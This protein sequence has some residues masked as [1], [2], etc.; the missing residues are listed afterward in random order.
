MEEHCSLKRSSPRSRFSFPTRGVRNVCALPGPLPALSLRAAFSAHEA[1]SRV[2]SPAPSSL[3]YGV[4][5]MGLLLATTLFRSLDSSP[6][7]LRS[8][9]ARLSMGAPFGVPQR[10][11]VSQAVLAGTG[12]LRNFHLAGNPLV[13][14]NP[15]PLASG[16]GCLIRP[17]MR[18]FA[19]TSIFVACNTE[20]S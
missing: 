16:S 3:P 17:V 6:Q 18:L 4:P 9:R 11:E 13:T 14:G 8:A 10:G 12:K 20:G 19:G 2:R 15:S 5:R 1:R 7:A